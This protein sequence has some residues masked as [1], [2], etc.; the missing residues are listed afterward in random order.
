MFSG[1]YE[2]WRRTRFNGILKYIE[3]DFFINK[4]LLELGGGYGDNGNLFK[5]LGSIVTS[6][7][8]RNEHLIIGK[9]K[10]PDIKFELLDCDNDL[11]KEKY[12]IILH[13]GVLYHLKNIEF[14]LKNV[15]EKC[16]YLL[17]ETEVCNSLDD[18]TNL[19]LFENNS[20]DQA[21]N[22]YGSRPS[23]KMIEKILTNSNFNFKLIMDP[24]LNSGIHKYDWE[25]INS[26]DYECGKRRFWICWKNNIE[27]P[28]KVIDN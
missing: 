1:H 5:N 10:Y 22:R 24:I 20:Y 13:W 8:A 26:G 17:L 25:N 15:C 18:S 3:K 19:L 11:I 6:S 21:Y 16:D 7:D 14:N 2:D 23:E 9:N 27:F 28:I 12:D 4:S